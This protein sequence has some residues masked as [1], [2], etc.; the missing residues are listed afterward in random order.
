M[1][2]ER[3]FKE[4]AAL[5]LMRWLPADGQPLHTLRSI[6][7]SSKSSYKRDCQVLKSCA[8]IAPGA[9]SS[10]LR[11]IWV[12]SEACSDSGLWESQSC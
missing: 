2:V 11:I 4:G 6:T 9:W 7:L 12:P 10:P 5:S 8:L 3:E 1:A